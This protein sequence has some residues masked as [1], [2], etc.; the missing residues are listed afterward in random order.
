MAKEKIL[1]V[2][3]E[4]DIREL[5]SY[6]LVKNGYYA[7]TVATG[8]EAVLR[9]RSD[10]PDLIVLDLML[11]G[12]DGFDVCRRLK[13]DPATKHIPILML[14][15][16]SDEIDIVAGL[17]L[18][19]DDY[20]TKPFSPRVLLARIRALMR[21][22]AAPESDES[23]SIKRGEVVIDMRRHE[24]RVKDQP[25]ELTHTEFMTLHF[26]AKRPGWV[27]SRSQIIGA[28]HGEAYP[29]TERSVDV[30]IVGLRKKLGEFG[31]RIETVRGM[32]YRFR[33]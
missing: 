23:E 6:N 13:G 17:E 32:G 12:A 22:A 15:A 10:Q 33:E 28:V 18:G 21:K 4:K 2:D 19:A 31:D 20:V 29:V 24:V 9:A 26:L 3:D 1:V 25:V 16:R 8:E 7:E 11:P 14:T 5:V 27:F 30:Q